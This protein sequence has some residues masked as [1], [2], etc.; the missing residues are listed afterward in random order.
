MARV[1]DVGCESLFRSNSRLAKNVA[2][3]NNGILRVWAGLAF[4]RQR[5]F[6][7]E[8]DHRLLGELQHEVAQR[9]DG[10]L[11][12]DAGALRIVKLGMTAVHFRFRSANQLVEQVVS[13]DA[14]ALTSRYLN[15]GLG[16]IFI[17]D[18]VTQLQRAAWG[19]GDHLVRKMC[20]VR[21][22]TV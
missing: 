18:L 22:L 2:G 19:E 7:V 14:E 10:D 5:F 4:K 21:G 8:G 17:A 3:A 15:V 11:R 12:G 6:E 13:L 20:V 9:A 16:A 1:V